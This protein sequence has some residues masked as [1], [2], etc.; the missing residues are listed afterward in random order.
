M[1]LDCQAI[2]GIRVQA[3]T[4]NPANAW[5]QGLGSTRGDEEIEAPIRRH[6]LEGTLNEI[7]ILQMTLSTSPRDPG[8]DANQLQHEPTITNCATSDANCSAPASTALKWI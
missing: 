1:L 2:D 5:T 3:T 4:E 6:T 7:E 8:I